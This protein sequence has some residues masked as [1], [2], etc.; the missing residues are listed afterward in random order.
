MTEQDESAG[1]VV[2]L[3][4]EEDV[5]AASRAHGLAV[6][7]ETDPD[8]PHD[9]RCGGCEGAQTSETC[10]FSVKQRRA[11]ERFREAS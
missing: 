11:S 9:P 3:C 6:V 1:P 2:R 10:P 7:S 4:R 8:G 5:A